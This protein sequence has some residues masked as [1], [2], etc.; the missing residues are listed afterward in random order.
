MYR[1]NFFWST[2]C[3]QETFSTSQWK[4]FRYNTCLS[5]FSSF[6][7]SK[8]S[9][10]VGGQSSEM[11]SYLGTGPNYWF[12]WLLSNKDLWRKCWKLVWLKVGQINIVQILTK[13]SYL[14][15]VTSLQHKACSLFL[16]YVMYI[17]FPNVWWFPISTFVVGEM[18]TNKHQS[19]QLR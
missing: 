10:L 6:R 5:F 14:S 15:R 19:I 12:D 4:K 8:N 2:L 1:F 16:Q 11:R 13:Y 7:P 18:H 9:L 3:H 17:Q